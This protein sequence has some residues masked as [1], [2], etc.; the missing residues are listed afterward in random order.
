MFNTKIVHTIIIM[1]KNS[2][3]Q[4]SNEDQILKDKISEKIPSEIKQNCTF[5]QD[6]I[7]NSTTR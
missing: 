7:N 3:R 6:I 5:C 4:S 1:V 2:L